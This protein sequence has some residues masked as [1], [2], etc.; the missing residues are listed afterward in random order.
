MKCAGKPVDASQ[1]NT[2]GAEGY[3][4]DGAQGQMAF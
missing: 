2:A 1:Q 3:Y 4:F